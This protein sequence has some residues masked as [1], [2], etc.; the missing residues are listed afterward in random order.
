MEHENEFDEKAKAWDDDPQHAKRAQTIAKA[1]GEEIPNDPSLTAMEYGCGTGL[2]SFPLRDRFSK[3]TLIDSSKGMLEVLKEKITRSGA[4]NMEALNIDLL[5]SPKSFSTTF[6]V[7]YS[8]MVLHHIPDISKMLSTWH[9]LLAHPGYLFIADLD[10]DKGLFHGP[11]F[12]GH[13]GF[14]RND[15]QKIAEKAGF[16]EV[17]FRTVSEINKTASDGVQ[18]TFP[19]FLMVCK[20]T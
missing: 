7:I 4:T 20:K 14:D 16:V 5:E 1:I 2:L 11:E 10:S 9:S 13:N 8:A 6:S 15:L 19:L 12:K 3:I 18:R 17:K